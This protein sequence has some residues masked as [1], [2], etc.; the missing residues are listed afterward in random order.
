MKLHAVKDRVVSWFG[1][2]TGFFAALGSAPATCHTLCMSFIALLAVI[3]ITVT[4]MPFAFITEYNIVFWSVGATFLGLGWLLW[5]KHRGCMSGKLLAAN[6]GFIVAG[7]P[8]VQPPLQYGFW[9]TG[10][11]VVVGAVGLFVGQKMRSNYRLK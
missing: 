8:F 7:F 6:A 1:G 2:I 11:V 10:A 5:W 4:G 3:G 9:I